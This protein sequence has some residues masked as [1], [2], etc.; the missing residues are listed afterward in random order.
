MKTISI[1]TLLV[2]SAQNATAGLFYDLAPHTSSATMKLSGV[3]RVAPS[4]GS[5]NSATITLDGATGV[6]TASTFTG[7]GSG[8]TSGSIDTA[9]LG[10]DSVT[11]V[12]VLAGAIETN[13]LADG[14]VT[15]Q[16]VSDA[17]VQTAK[18]GTDSVTAVKVLAGAIQ[19]DKLGTDAV[20]TAKVQAQAITSPKLGQSLTLVGDTT[21]NG[22]Q[23]WGMSGTAS[24]PTWSWRDASNA[25][26]YLH[27][28]DGTYHT[29]GFAA[30]GARIFHYIGKSDGAGSVDFNPSGVS[31]DFRVRGVG[32][33]A[34]IHTAPVTNCVGIRTESCAKTLDIT[35]TLATTS[36]VE[37]GGNVRI[38]DSGSNA[39]PAIRFAGDTGENT[40]MGLKAQN[41][42]FWSANASE[43]M[44][45]DTAGL[46]VT[47]T[48]V[49]N[50]F[51]G[52][53][54]SLTSIPAAALASGSVE[55]AKIAS[56]AVIAA[57]ILEGAVETAKIGTDAVTAVKVQA[58]AITTPKIA[59]LAVETGKIGTDAIIAAKISAGAVTSPKIQN[60]P[61]LN[62]VTTFS[63]SSSTPAVT[64]GW[65]NV[66]GAN[67]ANGV[68][69]LG[70]TAGFKASIDHDGANGITRYINDSATNARH[71]FRVNGT[72]GSD[73]L[74]ILGTGISN[75][76]TG[77][78]HSFNASGA[79]NLNGSST[80]LT[81]TGILNVASQSGARAGTWANGTLANAVFTRA[82]FSS[83]ASPGFNYQNT[84]NISAASD[85]FKAR[86]AGRYEAGLV[87]V[88][89]NNGAATGA[90]LRIIAYKN[91]TP[92]VA[93]T[94]TEV[95]RDVNPWIT[96]VTQTYKLICHLDL[97]DGDTISFDLYNETGTAL[98]PDNDNSY[99]HAWLVKDL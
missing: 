70:G 56:S 35:G 58:Q 63:N 55:T 69:G 38:S 19:T 59:D 24:T 5:A 31:N 71:I 41:T 7:S 27:A 8:L 94:G 49:A 13:K 22:G 36:N 42:L 18:L 64:S 14:A 48:V 75:S 26:M 10:A 40:G 43:I 51:S 82:F 76:T 81:T 95:C 45:M 66:G 91:A 2:L 28:D 54:A 39:T 9:K 46:N 21:L 93:S 92:G 25:G 89:K 87:S 79:V 15:A 65:S 68:L 17:A 32:E 53:G 77:G 85:T 80:T 4:T 98:T 50:T 16:K 86:G 34:L 30:K 96:G 52:S 67:A 20:T 47:G 44:T 3:M 73:V 74:Q 99:Q 29:V 72:F 33:A 83:V 97:A 12:K 6:V 1:L 84:I 62:G 88:Q 61:T 90:G 11:A 57:K 78:V 37:F 23:A 60:S